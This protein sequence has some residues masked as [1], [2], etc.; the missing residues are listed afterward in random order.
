M[1]LTDAE[2]REMVAKVAEERGWPTTA[3]N[4]REDNVFCAQV[5]IGNV[6]GAMREALALGVKQ[7]RERI[8]I[9]LQGT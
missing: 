8:L 7:E 3:R 9:I 6:Y 4:L 5:E 2:I 1:A